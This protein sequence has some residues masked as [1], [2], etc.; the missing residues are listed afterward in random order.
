MGKFCFVCF[1][2]LGDY[3]FKG[4]FFLFFFLFCGGSLFI[5]V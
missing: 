4:N 1:V 2:F 5:F 3:F